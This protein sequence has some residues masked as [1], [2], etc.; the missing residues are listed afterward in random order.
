[1]ATETTTT[2]T[3]TYIALCPHYWGKGSTVDEA[4]KNMKE[5]GGTLVRYIV[6]LLP[7]GAENATVDPF[8]GT[9]RWEWA[10][11]ANT[12]LTT[13]VVAKRGVK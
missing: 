4:K 10:E 1:M 13:E 2:T 7:P 9:I 11:G 3:H 6:F 5:P 12:S 8:D